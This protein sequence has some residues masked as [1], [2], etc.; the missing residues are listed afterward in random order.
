M[1]LTHKIALI[2]NIFKIMH[3]HTYDK[4]EEKGDYL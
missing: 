4:E 3:I 2:Q 1:K